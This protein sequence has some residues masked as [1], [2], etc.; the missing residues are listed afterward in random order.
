MIAI[1]L[2]WGLNNG[3]ITE[4]LVK[5]WYLCPWKESVSTFQGLSSPRLHWHKS[6]GR[7]IPG[8]FW[9]HQL[10]SMKDNFS[11]QRHPFS[12]SCH[13]KQL[14]RFSDLPV[15]GNSRPKR[16]VSEVVTTKE[17]VIL[18]LFF[19]R[20]TCV[21]HPEQVGPD[22]QAKFPSRPWWAQTHGA[23]LKSLMETAA[24]AQPF[25]G[26]PAV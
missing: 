6:S 18:K 15:D 23:L 21:Q 1:E 3:Y 19:S 7:K 26:I 12:R 5:C 22:C 10:G 4:V 20:A 25:D 9:N 14:R 24:A 17:Q 8:I 16:H 2:L 13:S 11:A